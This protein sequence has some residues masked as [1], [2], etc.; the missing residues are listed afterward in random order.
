MRWLPCRQPT[1]RP[2]LTRRAGRRSAPGAA[3]AD[4]LRAVDDVHPH[5]YP[6]IVPAPASGAEYAARDALLL[7]TG[8]GSPLVASERSAVRALISAAD[9]AVG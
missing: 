9:A 5:A 1:T 3:I 2:G 4:A 8:P 6:G 7:L